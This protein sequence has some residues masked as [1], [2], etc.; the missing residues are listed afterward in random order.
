MTVSHGFSP[1]PG[2]VG[3]EAA[4]VGQ[5]VVPIVVVVRAA[6]GDLAMADAVLVV[7][8]YSVVVVAVAPP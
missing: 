6:A 4:L 1:G 2:G 7:R 5:V 8:I 3:D